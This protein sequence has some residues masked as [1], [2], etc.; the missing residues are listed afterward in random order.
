MKEP[1]NY[2][3]CYLQCPECHNFVLYDPHRIG[4]ARRPG[5]C[6]VCRSTLK[7]AHI[8]EVGYVS[9]SEC[10][11]QWTQ[12]KP[13]HSPQSLVPC[14]EHEVFVEKVA[15]ALPEVRLDDCSVVG[16]TVR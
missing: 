16:G 6:Q 2:R 14:P 15:L 4:T 1:R 3:R 5:L 7:F 8:W 9:E 10:N 12:E 13:L 11:A